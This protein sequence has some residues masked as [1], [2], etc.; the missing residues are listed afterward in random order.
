MPATPFLPGLPPVAARSLTAAFDAGRL[1]SDGGLIVLRE[2]ASRLG[3]VQAIAARL[4]DDRDSTRVLRSS[5]ARM[6]MI[7]L[8]P[9]TRT[10]TT[11]SGADLMVSCPGGLENLADW[12][13]LARIGLGGIDLYCRSFVQPPQRIILDMDD[14]DDSS[15]NS[16]WCAVTA[17]TAPSPRWC[18]REPCA[19]TNP[20]TGR[21]RQG[22]LREELLAVRT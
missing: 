12:R 20:R 17:P 5:L 16:P 7:A 10:A 13:A 21:G 22:A 14:I 19:A 18:C 8:Q 15:S 1:S 11:F 9:A 2:I 6:L 4:R 3:L